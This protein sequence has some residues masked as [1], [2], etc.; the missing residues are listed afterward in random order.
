MN[1]ATCLLETW[2]ALQDLGFKQVKKVYSEQDMG[3]SYD[4][5][6]F[7][8]AAGRMMNRYMREVWS[9][10]GMVGNSNFISSIEFEMPLQ[11]ESIE[12]CAAWVTWHLQTHLPVN[13]SHFLGESELTALGRQH[14]S[15]L[16]WVRKQA[17][18][19]AR[20]HCMAKRDWLRLALN[21]LK[22]VL[23]DAEDSTEVQFHFDGT[24]LVVVCQGQRIVCPA[25]G[26][27]WPNHYIIA[28]LHLRKLPKRLMSDMPCVDIWEGCLG[29]DRY[30]Y[31]GVCEQVQQQA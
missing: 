28:A 4:F 12:Q 22:S 2:K 24:V 26:E 6:R 5:G 20:S 15:T 14:Q 21:E 23:C 9:F 10:S 1:G 16:P 11:I 3:L 27:A 13:Q 18:Y 7:Q 19:A 30:R 17:A 31:S 25:S 29:I 8:I